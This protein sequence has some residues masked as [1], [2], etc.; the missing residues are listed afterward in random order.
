M[1]Q[2]PAPMTTEPTARRFQAQMR[3]AG[4]RQRETGRD[5]RDGERD[6]C[7]EDAVAQ[8]DRHRE[9]EHADEVHRPDAHAHGSR[10]AEQPQAS[11]R[12][13]GFGDARGEPERRVRHDH[14]DQ[15]GQGDQP[16]VVARLHE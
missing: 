4:D 15:D 1:A 7:L 11:G 5:H 8:R 14:R 6:H 13:S 16:E 3:A 2:M 9:R 12:S 10:A